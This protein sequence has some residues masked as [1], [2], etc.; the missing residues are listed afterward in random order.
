MGQCP[1]NPVKLVD[2]RGTMP[3]LGKIAIF[4]NSGIFLPIDQPNLGS[5]QK[6]PEI[7]EISP[8]KDIKKKKKSGKKKKKDQNGSNL[9]D[10]RGTMPVFTGFGDFW[11]FGVK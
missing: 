4:G 9:V 2:F 5:G 10:F 1:K 7:G 6:W 8:Q 3:V 11:G